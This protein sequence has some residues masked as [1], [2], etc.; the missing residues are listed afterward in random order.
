MCP[1][2]ANNKAVRDRISAGLNLVYAPVRK[3]ID[4]EIV[5]VLVETPE[6]LNEAR[7]YQA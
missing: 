3:W 2:V 1:A 4:G 6:N 7:Q 5:D